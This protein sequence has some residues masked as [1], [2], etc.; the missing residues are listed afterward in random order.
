MGISD[1]R[2]KAI[3]V[4]Q[5][6]GNKHGGKVEVVGRWIWVSFPGVPGIEIREYLKSNQFRWNFRRQTWQC[7]NGIKCRHAKADT[8]YVK[9]KYDAQE[10]AS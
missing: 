10:V 6:V 9:A 5:A 8:W 1:I 4:N 7:A 3:A 2:E